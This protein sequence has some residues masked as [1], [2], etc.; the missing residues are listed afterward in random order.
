MTPPHRGPRHRRHRLHRRPVDPSSHRRRPPRWRSRTQC[1]AG[2]LTVLGGAGRDRRGRRAGP[3]GAVASLGRGGLR[4]LPDPQ[5]G[6]R[7]GVL[8]AEM[9]LPGRAWLQF[10]VWET[11]D[12]TTRLEQ[13]AAFLP[14]GLGGLLYWYGCTRSMLGS[15]MGWRGR[16]SR[17]APKD[18]RA[19]WRGRSRGAPGGPGLRPKNSNPVYGLPLTQYFAGHT[20][21]Y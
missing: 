3:R 18:L 15:S 10:R 11:E 14:K 6:E 1:R 21:K 5:H 16:P 2:A 13:T 12:G 7:R 4:L 8:R 9:K 17:G 20:R 19:G